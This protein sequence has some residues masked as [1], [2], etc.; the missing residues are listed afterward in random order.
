MKWA[1]NIAFA[2][3]TYWI[4]TGKHIFKVMHDI[5]ETMWIA[6]YVSGFP[7][8]YQN[9]LN[10]R[11]VSTQSAFCFAPAFRQ[12]SMATMGFKYF[13][14]CL[15]SLAVAWTAEPLSNA[16]FEPCLDHLTLLQNAT[17]I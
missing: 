8:L 13:S 16:A 7:M 12:P 15:F 1:L 9:R 6:S 10:V 17:A 14:H 3:S 4:A 2:Q 5:Q 11:W